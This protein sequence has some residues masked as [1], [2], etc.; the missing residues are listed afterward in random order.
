MKKAIITG[1][2]IFIGFFIAGTLVWFVHDKGEYKKLKY[3]K[4]FTSKNLNTL[5]IDSYTSDVAIK[6]GKQFRVKYYGDNDIKVS[7]KKM[8]LI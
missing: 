2:V 5:N 1:L 7:P 8:K 4:E 3:N 6:K